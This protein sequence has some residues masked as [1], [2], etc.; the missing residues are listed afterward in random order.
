MKVT[1]V[2]CYVVVHGTVPTPNITNVKGGVWGDDLA[3]LTES[4]YLP[5]FTIPINTVWCFSVGAQFVTVVSSDI[6]GDGV[7]HT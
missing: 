4:E 7:T 6:V 3:Q 1:V 2:R 5:S